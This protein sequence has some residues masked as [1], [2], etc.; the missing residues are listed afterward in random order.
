MKGKGEKVK[1]TNKKKNNNKQNKTTK[2]KKPNKN[3]TR[4]KRKENE[5]IHKRTSFNLHYLM[6]VEGLYAIGCSQ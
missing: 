5:R 4:K 1:K 3:K 2:K 6:R